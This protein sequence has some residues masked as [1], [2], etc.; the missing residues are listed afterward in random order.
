VKNSSLKY[1]CLSAGAKLVSVIDR[2]RKRVFPQCGGAVNGTH[3]PIEAS[4]ENAADY[5]D[6]NGWHWYYAR[7]SDYKALF[8]DTILCWLA[9]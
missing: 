7:C 4:R 8:T 5:H 1:I 9:R 6:C 3:I 2:F